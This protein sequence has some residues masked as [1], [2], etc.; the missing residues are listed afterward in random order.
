MRGTIKC[1]LTLLIGE[2]LKLEAEDGTEQG[3]YV[4]AAM[5][6]GFVMR[7]V[8]ILGVIGNIL[9]HI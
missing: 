5:N 9:V 2:E 6:D 1:A 8:H 7:Y 3:K 4:V